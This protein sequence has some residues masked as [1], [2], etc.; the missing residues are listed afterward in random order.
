MDE[1]IINQVSELIIKTLSF[2]NKKIVVYQL[3]HPQ[4]RNCQKVKDNG[5][6]NITG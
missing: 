3:I 6:W 1:E 2:N 4:R 5:T